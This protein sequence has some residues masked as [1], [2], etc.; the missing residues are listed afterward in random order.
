MLGSCEAS[1]LGVA[2]LHNYSNS[3]NVILNVDMDN[4]AAREKLRRAVW[5][6]GL[7]LEQMRQTSGPAAAGLEGSVFNSA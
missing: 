6:G 7:A 4:P 3:H 5:C 1:H 2:K